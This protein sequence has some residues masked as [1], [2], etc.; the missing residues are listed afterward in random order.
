MKTNCQRTMHA[1]LHLASLCHCFWLYRGHLTLQSSRTLHAFPASHIL[2]ISNISLKISVVQML[3]RMTV[4]G[5][6]RLVDSFS[7]CGYSRWAWLFLLGPWNPCLARKTF[8]T[9]SILQK[10]QCLL[11]NRIWHQLLSQL[12]MQTSL[13]SPMCYTEADASL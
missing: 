5:T 1:L 13:M 2:L 7:S 9:G 4:N 11:S 10:W 12:C 3:F 8:I 6:W